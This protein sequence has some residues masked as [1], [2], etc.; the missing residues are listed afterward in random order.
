MACNAPTA[1]EATFIPIDA[2]PPTLDTSPPLSFSF[3]FRAFLRPAVLAATDSPGPDLEDAFV[4]ALE[5]D[6]PIIRFFFRDFLE[7]AFVEALEDDPPII[8]F[9][10]EDVGSIFLIL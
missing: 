2:P 8:R 9:V 1:Y 3:A 6:P 7:D 4:E 10:L 5:D